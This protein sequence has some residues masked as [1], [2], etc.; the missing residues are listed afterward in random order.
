M[1]LRLKKFWHYA[2]FK[3]MMLNI[4][5]SFNKALGVEILLKSKNSTFYNKVLCLSTYM[6]VF[7]VYITLM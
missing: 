6:A 7:C 3:N 5:S 1:P 4:Q 2:M